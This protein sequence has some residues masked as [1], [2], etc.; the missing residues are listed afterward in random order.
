MLVA[1]LFMLVQQI[2]KL[3]R[4]TIG[5][6]WSRYLL[7][8]KMSTIVLFFCKAVAKSGPKMEIVLQVP[9]WYK[10]SQTVSAEMPER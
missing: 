2:E 6:I 8:Y 3:A 5:H 1:W 7:P 4:L 10:S 9:I